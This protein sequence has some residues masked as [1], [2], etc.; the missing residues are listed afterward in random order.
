[1]SDAVDA[2]EMSL[3]VRAAVSL[4]VVVGA[5]AAALDGDSDGG[6]CSRPR[7][8]FSDAA[9]RTVLADVVMSVQCLAVSHANSSASLVDRL[10]FTTDVVTL[11]FVVNQTLK[12]RRATISSEPGARFLKQLLRRSWENLRKMTEL[13]KILGIIKL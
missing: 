13:T 5:A 12:G 4:L 11:T 6:A 7:R 2:A 8:Q 9:S 3:A 10:N 1:M